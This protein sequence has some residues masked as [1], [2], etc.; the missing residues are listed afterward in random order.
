MS[1]FAQFASNIRFNIYGQ[2]L[3]GLIPFFIIPYIIHHLGREAYALYALIGILTGQ[4][5]LLHFGA[6]P[7]TIKYL[8]EFHAA[9]DRNRTRRL[10]GT[11][12]LFYGGIGLAGAA[13]LAVCS[14][15]L[16]RFIQ[17]TPALGPAVRFVFLCAAA[18]FLLQSLSRIFQAVPQALQ[19]FD[20]WNGIETGCA[21][22][23]YAGN[24]LILWSGHWLRSMAALNIFVAAVGLFVYFRLSRKL[25]PESGIRLDYD[26]EMMRRIVGLG[27]PLFI[28]QLFWSVL[29]QADKIALGHFVPLSD[30]AYYLVAFSLAQ[31]L[32]IFLNPVMPIVMPL[33]S[34]LHGQQDMAAARKLYHTGTKLTVILLWPAV[35]AAF[36]FAPAFLE[37]WLGGQFSLFGGW[38]LRFLVLGV[39]MSAVPGFGSLI[40]QGFG[41]VKIPTILFAAHVIAAAVLWVFIVPRHGILGAT[42]I[43]CASQ[44]SYGSLLLLWCH[45]NVL[46]L[47][48]KDLR[49]SLSRPLLLSIPVIVL[50][51]IFRNL[52][53]SWFSL[54]PFGACSYVLYGLLCYR[55]ALDTE[56]HDRLS[57]FMGSWR[58]RRPP[59]AAAR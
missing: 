41:Q 14:P 40:S 2:I 6:V 39:F 26:A 45:K 31:K 54:L 11:S 27:G 12:L 43:F 53:R 47:P 3:Q 4:L 58:A 35:V 9:G 16:Q 8:A 48:L 24:F 29:Y 34:A 32:F 10:M 51:M 36:F 30:L 20:Y 18:T 44:I 49:S 7:A 59:A 23:L 56:E 22:L 17:T 38:V 5:N 42:W 25:L 19:R 15:L 55:F 46:G 1:R 50:D 13:L 37:L 57:S 52:L 21:M 33:A 28:A